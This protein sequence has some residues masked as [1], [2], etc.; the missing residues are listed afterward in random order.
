[1]NQAFDGVTLANSL[2]EL[3]LV[4]EYW[5][6]LCP[7]RDRRGTNP[8]SVRTPLTLVD[9]PSPP[10]P[11]RSAEHICPVLTDTQQCED[12]LCGVGGHS[13]I[14]VNDCAPQRPR[15]PGSS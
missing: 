5:I 11:A 1:M 3:G 12:P 8:V 6:K 7:T 2:V 14:A 9:S 15:S 4:D 10:D 13:P